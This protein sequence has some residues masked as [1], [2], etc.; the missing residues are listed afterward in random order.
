MGLYYLLII[1][2]YKLTTVLEPT[3]RKYNSCDRWSFMY[4][5]INPKLLFFCHKERFPVCFF[6][7]WSALHNKESI[8]G[9]NCKFY[10]KK[11]K[12][13][14]TNIFLLADLLIDFFASNPPVVDIRNVATI[15]LLNSLSAFN[16]CKIS[17]F[18]NLSNSLN[19]FRWTRYYKIQKFK[20]N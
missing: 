19:L 12:V 8:D 13:Y 4:R 14:H 16:F 18:R 17:T 3:R 9:S 11:K 1:I 2:I 6:I 7:R 10:H 15:S 5:K 20:Q